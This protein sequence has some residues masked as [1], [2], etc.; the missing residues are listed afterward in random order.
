M[1]QTAGSEYE[2]IVI[3]NYDPRKAC[4]QLSMDS[5]LGGDGDT[6]YEL[7]HEPEHPLKI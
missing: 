6:R 2:E 5:L 7:I 1:S 3:T 4:W